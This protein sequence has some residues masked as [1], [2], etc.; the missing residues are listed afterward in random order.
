MLLPRP[1]GRRFGRF[2]LWTL[3]VLLAIC[4]AVAIGYELQTSALQAYLLPRYTAKVSY[5]LAEG[6][7]QSIAFPRSAPFDDRLGYSHLGDF[8][9]RLVER[10]FIVDRQ[11]VVSPELVRLVDLDIAPPY[12]EPLVAGLTIHGMN[13][14]RLYDAARSARAFR[15][16]DDVPPLL[17][18]TLLF[19]ENRELLAPIDP[20]ANPAIEWD[21]MAKAS[22]LYAG[23]KL[24]MSFPIQGGSTLAIQLEKYRHSPNGRTNSPLDKLR[25]V[26]GASLKAYREGADTRAW[27]RQIVVDYF[28]T[29][30]LAA[31]PGYGE[32]YGIGDALYAWFGPT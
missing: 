2:A 30:P 6:P 4:A 8:Q 11:A 20:R 29:A 22:L 32:I 26:A 3:G 31:A 10:G 25:Q 9:R 27:R 14:T 17:V 23:S 13:G 7:S 24:G 19:I 21:R 18:Q 16:F 12:Q 15:S 28:N 1:A 5:K